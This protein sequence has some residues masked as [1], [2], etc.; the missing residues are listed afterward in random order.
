ME[1][2]QRQQYCRGNLAEAE[3]SR[4]AAVPA[5]RAAQETITLMQTL[6][7]STELLGNAMGITRSSQATRPAVTIAHLKL[8]NLPPN[9]IQ[10]LRPLL[11]LHSVRP[12][13][14][15]T[16]PFT[17]ST[18]QCLCAIVVA[19]VLLKAFRIQECTCPNAYEQLP[20]GSTYH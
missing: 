17:E 12:S 11:P 14:W 1:A 18:R 19:I 4:L 16:L 3:V 10:L 7:V 13:T 15:S 6:N 9:A 2:A 8:V 20:Y 5:G